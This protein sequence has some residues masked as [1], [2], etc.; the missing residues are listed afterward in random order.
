MMMAE[1]EDEM[2]SMIRKLEGYLDSKDLGV[3]TEKTKI[4][5][6]RKGSGRMSKRNWRWKRR[7]IGKK[8]F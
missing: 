6:F 1:K 5:W 2:T 8:E 3:N 4:M 7:R